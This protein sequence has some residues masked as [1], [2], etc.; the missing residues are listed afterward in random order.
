MRTTTAPTIFNSGVK[1]NVL[2]AQAKAVINFRI[3]PGDTISSVVNHIKKTV[4]NSQI[5]IK[6]LDGASNPSDVSSISTTGFKIIQKSIAEIFSP[7][8]IAPSLVIGAS[9][10]RHYAVVTKNIY[11]FLPLMVTKDDLAR[12]HGTN[13]RISFANYEKVVKFYIQLIRNSN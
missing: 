9:D 11:K 13:E 6:V 2:P 8:I 5:K 1:D 10:S 3:L 12:I 7:V 4:N